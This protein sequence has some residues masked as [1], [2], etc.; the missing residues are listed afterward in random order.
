MERAIMFTGR[1]GRIT[2]E[3]ARIA[4][5]PDIVIPFLSASAFRS[6]KAFNAEKRPPK[7]MM[8]QASHASFALKEA[9]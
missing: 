6:S 7:G 1:I 2:H 3:M 9:F 5:L 4:L 8:H